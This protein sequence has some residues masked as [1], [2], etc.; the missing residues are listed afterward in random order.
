MMNADAPQESFTKSQL[1]LIE[2]ISF[3]WGFWL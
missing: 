3:W 1:E 2:Y